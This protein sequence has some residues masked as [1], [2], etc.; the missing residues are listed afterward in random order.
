M[1]P[2]END[3]PGGRDCSVKV[4]VHFINVCPLK[5]PNFQPVWHASLS[6]WPPFEHRHI[7]MGSPDNEPL[8]STLCLSIIATCST[9]KFHLKMSECIA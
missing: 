1:K 5:K 8:Y 6:R 4:S 2:G 3:G 9:S 7:K